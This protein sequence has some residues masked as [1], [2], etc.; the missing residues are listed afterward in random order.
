MDFR[1][2]NALRKLGFLTWVIPAGFVIPGCMHPRVVGV[3]DLGEESD[4][5]GASALEPGSGAWR[6]QE[7]LP[8]HLEAPE[9]QNSF[10][11]MGSEAFELRDEDGA[12]Q[13][14]LE[15]NRHDEVSEPLEEAPHGPVG[16]EDSVLGGQEAAEPP[17]LESNLAQALPFGA[18][19][20][21]PD[22]D[23]LRRGQQLLDEGHYKAALEAFGQLGEDSPF[24]TAAL[25]KIQETSNLAV[26][27]LR[28][29]AA[30][31]FQT[32]LPV[33][34]RKARWHYL[35]QA[36]GY[37]E[38]A[39]QNYPGAHQIATV[40]ENLGVIESHLEALQRHST[41]A[42]AAEESSAIAL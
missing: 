10:A 21:G 36:K 15:V 34:D 30:K 13:T 23:I 33:R 18:L 24:Q 42:P 31:A 7:E 5:T 28:R 16:P 41:S 6:E 25:E 19:Q 22:E 1:W 17:T 39:L 2:A 11:E 37:L 14:P 3:A 40:R 32:A 20:F 8:A 9:M 35:G 38:A 29:S 12:A 4:L 27:E 26:A